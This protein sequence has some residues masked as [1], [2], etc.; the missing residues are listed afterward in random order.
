MATHSSILAWRIPWTK[1]HGRLQSKESY[2]NEQLGTQAQGELNQK[3]EM[4]R[5]VLLALMQRKELGAVGCNVDP[6]R[7]CHIQ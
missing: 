5:N 6:G 2:M 3:N 1:E 7:K 4:K